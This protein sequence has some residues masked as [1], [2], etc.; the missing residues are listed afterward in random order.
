MTTHPAAIAFGA[1][2][3]RYDAVFTDSAIGRAQRNAVWSEL[4]REFHAGDRVLEINCGTGEDALMLARRGVSVDAYDVA[5]GMIEVARRRAL[6]QAVSE[7][8]SFRVLAAEDL[9][10]IRERYDG[11]FSNFGGLN[12]VPHLNRVACELARVV[13]PGGSLVVCLAG[14]F[15]AWE[16]AWYVASCDFTR[17]TRRWRGSAEASLGTARVPVYYPTAKA[18]AKAFSPWFRLVRRRGIGVIV[19]PSY[20]QA[21]VFG[22]RAFVALAEKLDCLFGR[23][24]GTRAVADHA[25]FVLRRLA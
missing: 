20:A 17:A 22:T 15:C 6:V 7:R 4:Y 23:V 24:A 25:L 5:A 19:P 12:C 16:L 13:R 2:A 3:E 10:E 21:S 1:M 11:A 18:L 9:D 14:R 8:V